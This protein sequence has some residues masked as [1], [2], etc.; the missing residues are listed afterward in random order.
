MKNVVKNTK[1]QKFITVIEK[2]P[3]MVLK[4]EFMVTLLLVHNVIILKC[5]ILLKNI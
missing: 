3:K 2:F 5:L 4:T 1:L